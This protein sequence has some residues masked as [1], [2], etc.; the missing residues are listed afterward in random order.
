MW[1]G[2]WW[3]TIFYHSYLTIMRGQA[4]RNTLL[5]DGPGRMPKLLTPS[6]GP[7]VQQQRGW[8]TWI[9][10]VGKNVENNTGYYSTCSWGSG[11]LKELPSPC[12]TQYMG[13]V[14]KRKDRVLKSRHPPPPRPL[15]ET[16]TL[17]DAVASL[18]FSISPT[19]LH[20]H[21][22]VSRFNP[23]RGTLKNPIYTHTHKQTN[24]Q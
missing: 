8:A 16:Q 15:H 2:G 24:S 9:S 3:Y 6:N 22:P 18:F 13:T 4:S 19:V 21:P 12:T 20:D 17:R 10:K 5:A 1:F 23:V 14:F 7:Q 11:D